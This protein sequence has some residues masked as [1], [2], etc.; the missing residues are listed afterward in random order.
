MENSDFNDNIAYLKTKFNKVLLETLWSDSGEISYVIEDG[1]DLHEYA[2]MDKRILEADRDIAHDF[3]GTVTN[4]SQTEIA[5]F[6]Y[7]SGWF[8]EGISDGELE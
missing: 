5:E 1:F 2:E 8:L 6:Q 4:K 7:R 3:T